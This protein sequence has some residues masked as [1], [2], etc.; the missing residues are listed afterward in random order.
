MYTYT[1]VRKS[2]RSYVTTTWG[3]SYADAM[4]RFLDPSNEGFMRAFKVQPQDVELIY[5]S[6]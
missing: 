4:A 5:F 1:V 6:W 3:D 2:D